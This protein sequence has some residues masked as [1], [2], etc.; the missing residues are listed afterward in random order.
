M[1]FLLFKIKC[2]VIYLS[3]NAEDA[4]LF[5]RL[6]KKHFAV[7]SLEEMQLSLY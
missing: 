1:F 3:L 2:S 5:A 7:E 6:Y 4:F